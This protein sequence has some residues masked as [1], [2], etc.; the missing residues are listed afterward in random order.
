MVMFR[1]RRE[2]LAAKYKRGSPSD[3]LPCTTLAGLPYGILLV[4]GGLF[5]G[6]VLG[7]CRRQL[8]RVKKR[9]RQSDS[10]TG[11]NFGTSDEAVPADVDGGI[12][13]YIEENGGPCVL[14]TKTVSVQ[15][16]QRHSSSIRE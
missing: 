12:I 4:L 6:T 1:S 13:C 16:L 3:R 9:M 14:S 5:V 10:V 15:V 2:V 7:V 8:F 11:A